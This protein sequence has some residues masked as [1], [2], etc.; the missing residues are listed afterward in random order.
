MSEPSVR[1]RESKNG[2]YGAAAF[3]S[4]IFAMW[5]E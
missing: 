4:N 2:N 5:H 1:D 3:G